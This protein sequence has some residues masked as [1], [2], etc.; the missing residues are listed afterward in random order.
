L[1][2]NS[3]KLSILNPIGRKIILPARGYYEDSLRTVQVAR[4]RVIVLLKIGTAQLAG[5]L[6]ESNSEITAIP[7]LI[8]EITHQVL[9]RRIHTPFG[10]TAAPGVG[11]ILSSVVV[12]DRV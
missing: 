4:R 5:L 8:L 2:L 6:N 11:G 3:C 10:T 9:E 1:V 7:K 12:N